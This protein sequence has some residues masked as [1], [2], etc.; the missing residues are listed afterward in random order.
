MIEFT[1]IDKSAKENKARL[2]LVRFVYFR[3]QDFQCKLIFVKFFANYG[4]FCD[5]KCELRI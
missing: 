5:S 3:G 1:K 4:R 2:T